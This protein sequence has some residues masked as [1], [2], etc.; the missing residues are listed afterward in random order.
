MSEY[1]RT[2]ISLT[3]LFCVSVLLSQS[4]ALHRHRIDFGALQSADRIE[5]RD[6]SAA[7]LKTLTDPAQVQAATTFIRQRETG[8]KDPLTGPVIPRIVLMFYSG[9]RFLGGFGVGDSSIVSYPP[10]DGFWS[11]DVPEEEIKKL[12]LTLDVK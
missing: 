2:R 6:T 3:A 12:L 7:V 4:C 9:T 5:V 8:W 11:R 1:R 10:K